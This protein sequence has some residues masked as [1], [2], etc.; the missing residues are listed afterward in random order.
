MSILPNGFSIIDNDGSEYNI[1]KF[2]KDFYEVFRIEN[3]PGKL[4]R[5]ITKYFS[6]H[7]VDSLMDNK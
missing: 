1:I 6:Q 3:L 2:E 5:Y 4:P 7:Y